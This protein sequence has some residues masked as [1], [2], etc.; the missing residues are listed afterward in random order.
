MTHKI[1][2]AGNPNCGKTCLFNN[3]TGTHQKTGN[4]PGVTV[5]QKSGSFSYNNL[6]FEVID[7]PGTYSISAYSIEE[8]VVETFLKETSPDVLINIV[9]ATNLKRHL[10]FTAQLIETGVPMILVLNMMDEAESKGVNVDEE[11]LSTM[12]GVPV[13]KTIARTNFGTKKLLSE[14]VQLIENPLLPKVKVDYGF[15]LEKTI[16][17]IRK[18]LKIENPVLGRKKAVAMLAGKESSLEIDNETKNSIE[19]LEERFKEPVIDMI[20]GSRYG[21]ANGVARMCVKKSRVV[22]FDLT[23]KIDNFLTHPILGLL[24]FG[25]FMWMTFQLVFT[26]GSPLMGLI[27]LGVES[28]ASIISSILPDGFLKSLIVDG[29][30]NGVGGILVFLPNILL[31]FLVIGFLEDSG[32]MARAAFVTDNIMHKMGLHGKSFIPM[33]VGFGCTVPAIMA[34][35]GLD[36]RKQR[37]V[38][39]LVSPFMSCS[40]RMPVYALFISAFFSK[41]Q[42][43]VMFSIYLV[44]IIVAIIMA[45][46][47]GLLFFGKDKTPLL[48]ELPPYRLPTLKSVITLMWMRGKMFIKKA[49]TIILVASV[50]SWFFLNYPKTELPENFGT[51]KFN[52]AE[53]SQIQIENSYFGKFGKFIEPVF[54]P[55]GFDWKISIGLI[56]GFAAK[57]V[58]VSTLGVIYGLGEMEEEFESLKNIIKK[59]M[60][61]VTAYA[62]MLFVLLYVPCLGVVSIFIKEF[63]YKW[64]SF[65]VF[66]TTAVAYTVALLARGIGLLFF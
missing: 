31:L 57:E 59:E 47:I 3:L 12:L 33:L 44:G 53:F 8:E 51:E 11:K 58:V 24:I 9:D 25:I 30:I 17:S 20:D 35:R 48:M 52:S 5:E 23:S 10:Y 55:L 66:Y 34:T 14:I 6:D 63:G 38:T 56:T 4:W 29:I 21:F 45:H 50:L 18:S 65:L 16:E 42:G 28:F 1:A 37:L 26:V 61:P 27:E 41:N 13:V 32:Y 19:M 22:R 60:S 64:T 54:K 49:G 39:A 15:E 62:L 36:T 2:I 46:I 40:A 43:L 7:L